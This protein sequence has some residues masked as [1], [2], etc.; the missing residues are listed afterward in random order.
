L[1]VLISLVLLSMLYWS[2]RFRQRIKRMVSRHFRRPF[3]DYREMWT[4]FTA[5]PP[6]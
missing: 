6:H 5:E 3:F 4:T 2:D 1:L